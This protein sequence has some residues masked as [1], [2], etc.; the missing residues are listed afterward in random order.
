M[1]IL[2]KHWKHD[3]FQLAAFIL[4]AVMINKATADNLLLNLAGLA[5]LIG[6]GVSNFHQGEMRA[7]GRHY[8]LKKIAEREARDGKAED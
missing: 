6:Y 1:R 4:I 3:L 2:D 5:F 8:L 7:E